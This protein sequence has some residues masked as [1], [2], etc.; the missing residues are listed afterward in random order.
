[1]NINNNINIIN[2]KQLEKYLGNNGFKELQELFFYYQKKIESQ[3]LDI[4]FL[5]KAINQAEKSICKIYLRRGMKASGFFC[6]IPFPDENNMLKVFI[7]NNH[8]IN[9]D[10]LYKKDEE[11]EITINE[12]KEYCKLNLNNRIKYTNKKFDITI[13]E[14]Q[15]ERDRIHN[16]LELDNK[17]LNDVIFN[18]D[19]KVEEYKNSAIYVMHYPYGKEL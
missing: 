10:I 4:N 18:N 2:Y 14:I 13:I 17:I 15:E 7:T 1:M 12:D 11:I 19:K 8:V 5:E 3:F 16:Y 9:E 6:K